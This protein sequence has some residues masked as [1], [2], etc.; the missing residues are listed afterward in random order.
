L[1]KIGEKYI[2]SD[3]PT[4]GSDRPYRHSPGSATAV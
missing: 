2:L 3:Q 1:L 4:G